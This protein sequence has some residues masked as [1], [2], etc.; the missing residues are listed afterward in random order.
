MSTVDYLGALGAGSGIDTQLVVNSLVEAERA[1]QQA[2]LD[3]MKEKADVRLSAFGVIKGTLEAV[4]DQFRKLNDVSDLKSFDTISSDSTKLTA[5]ASSSAQGGVYSIAVTQLAE[6]DSFSY[7]GFDSKTASLNGGAT[8][9]IDVTQGAT[10]TQLSIA[11]PTL[12]NI[13]ETINDSGLGL[14]A[15]IIDTGAASNRYV[16]SIS[17]DTGADNSFSVSS[18]VLTGEVQ[19]STAANATA[20]VNGVGITSATNR[21]TT[22]LPGLTLDLKATFAAETVTVS[23]D[24]SVIKQ[25]IKNLVT[26]YNEAR[27]IFASLRTGSD[28]DDPL[29]GS[30]A[31]DSVFRTV[32]S[33]FRAAFTAA[34]STP[35]GDIS[36]WAD[37]GLSIQRDGTLTLKED[38][39][40]SVLSSSLADV[41]TALTA[42]TEDQTDIGDASR[43]LA[44]DMSATIRNLVKTNGPIANAMTNSEQNLSDYEI[45]LT[46]LD[47]RME[48]IKERYLQQFAAMQR[49][50][51]S[52][53]STSQFLTNNLEAMQNKD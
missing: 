27:S 14:T 4:R 12:A 40:D 43:G 8:V 28:A 38:R 23:S 31:S 5:T 2:A 52:M 42:D 26:V 36:Y 22:A 30:M 25:E 10:T 19:Q 48:R 17:G 15:N 33:T 53:N 7:D 46:E 9:T 35:A 20:T 49:I 18:A 47:E 51:D 32:E 50:V 1:P 6:R 37:I 13:A 41:I 16:L 29:I 11:S 34:S 3:R 44:G 45:R 24:T 21:L 39:L